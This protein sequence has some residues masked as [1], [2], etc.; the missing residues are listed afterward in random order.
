MG[1]EPASLFLYGDPS[2]S[3]R[4]V[5]EAIYDGP[6]DT[7]NFAPVPVILAEKPDV[8]NGGARLEAVAV[9]P[10][11]EIVD[12]Q[13]NLVKLA[14]GVAYLPAGCTDA[15]C[16]VTYT[17]QEPASID[18]LVVTFKLRPE[19][20]WADGTPL[21]A[22]DSLYSF[23][24]ARQLFPQARSELLRR[25]QSYQVLDPAAVE[26]RGLPGYR[27]ARYAT[28]FFTPLPRHAWGELPAEE[29]LTAE[30]S[31]R[32]PLGWGPYVVEEWTAGDHISLV[33]NPA[34]FRAAEGLPHF[35]RVVFRFM[36]GA[37]EALEALLAGECDYVDET[38][39]LEAQGEA[40]NGQLLQLQDS[41]QINLIFET[42]TAWEHVD[43]GIQPYQP[44]TDP[45]V[46]PA[47]P[48]LFQARETRQ[49]VAQCIDRQRLAEELFF[50]QTQVADSY[51]SPA[52]PLY[53][54]EVR[55]YSFDPAAAAVLLDTAGWLDHDASPD[56]PRVAQGVLGVPDGTP[57]EFNYLTTGEAEKQLAAQILVESL[58]QCGIKMN[59]SQMPW[60]ELLAAGPDGPVFGRNFDMAQFAWVTAVE[61]P[62]F[63]YT[64]AEIPGPYPEFAK[65]WGGANASG[66]SSPDFDQACQ[67]AMTGLPDTTAY[68]DGHLR[69]QQIFAE[70]LPVI[71]LY[72]RLKLVATRPDLC[73]VVIDPSA[74][75]T[76]SSLETFDYGEGCQ[77]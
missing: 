42:G 14:E 38:L 32:R 2:V 65:G 60:E 18:Q 21:T 12:A 13:G 31:S 71:P 47:N 55:Q 40:Q 45:A 16:A 73:N 53:N 23:E 58:A 6:F 77:P 57:F 1:Q 25:T 34:Y 63:L 69:A 46:P 52:H 37:T 56:T 41:G 75:S 27:D 11:S 3:A 17:G 44:V 9:T 15:N 61:P 50:G 66:Y 36:P 19:I 24:V 54:P 67:Q 30:V 20:T 33:R 5:R 68:R 39:S 10:G 49:A 59:V 48:S 28:F 76:L 26:W 8:A 64:S 4:A 51:V 22:E 35:D 74:E 70:D 43:F 72:L 29:L 7:R 62:C